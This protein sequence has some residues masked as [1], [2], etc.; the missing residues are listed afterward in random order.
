MPVAL[1]VFR[2]G[3]PLNH[4]GL[5]IFPLFAD[6]T[7]HVEYR[8]AEEAL[9]GGS[10]TVEEIS[11]AGSVPELVV[12]N[13]GD[14]RILFLEGEELKGAKQNRILNTSVLVAAHS[15]L[16]VPVSCVEQ[17]RW[18]YS[19]RH[20]QSSGHHSP[21]KLRR[22][23]KA[24]VSESLKA[25]EGHRSD[26]GEVWQEVAALHSLMEVDSQTAAMSDAFDTYED[27]IADY[28]AQLKYVP[29]ARG[30]A[31]AIG[32]RIVSMDFF[33]KPETCERVWDRLLSGMVFDAIEAVRD[34]HTPSPADVERLLAAAGDLDWQPVEAIGEGTECRAESAQGDHA[35]ML[36]FNNVV[37]HGN[38][39]VNQR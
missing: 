1:P 6:S 30:L 21:S 35:S 27:R 23:V 13:R 25:R 38:I 7:G 15:K 22:A 4:D 24:S 31:A 32:S 37:V 19:G 17:G 3:E 36:A 11:E 10:A 28:R 14:S 8:I 5:S 39:M 2:V 34:D 9:A 29:G 12:E 26:Q 20:F 18:R 33:D 16:K